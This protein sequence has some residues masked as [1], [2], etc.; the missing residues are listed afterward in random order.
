MELKWM[1][2]K[3]HLKNRETWLRALYMA[4]FAFIYSFAEFV[5]AGTVILQ[6]GFVLI[7]GKKNTQL[8]A[9]G[10]NLSTFLYQVFL[11]LT[12]NTEDKPFPFAAWPTTPPRFSGEN[13]DTR[14]SD[15]GA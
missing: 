7:S 12:Y 13:S 15:N 14:Q 11:Y 3:S 10:Q 2:V 8:L 6:F 9:F 5:L 4:L 1:P